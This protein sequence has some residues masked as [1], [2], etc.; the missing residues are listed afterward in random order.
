MFHVELRFSNLSYLYCSSTLPEIFESDSSDQDPLEAP[1]PKA[2]KSRAQRFE[3]VLGILRE[4]R[5][6]PFDLMVELL[7]DSNLKYWAYR[8]ELY[9]EENQKLS[10]ILDLVFLNGPGKEKL[11]EWMLPHALEVVCSKVSDEMD[12]V[13]EV[14]KLPG[15][16]AITPEFIKAWRVSGHQEIAPFLFKIL[17]A[18]AETASAKEKNKNQA[19][20]SRQ[21]SCN[22]KQLL[23]LD[24]NC[25][26]LVL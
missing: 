6:S 5:L 15:L 22:H 24:K 13:Q 23:R 2:S 12:V 7:D 9:K 10:E 4:G 16:D 26:K 11:M 1:P 8:N 21:V 25:R 14:E 3:D 17:L 19:P 20:E 18:A